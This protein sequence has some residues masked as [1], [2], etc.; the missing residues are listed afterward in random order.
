M[1]YLLI[2]FGASFVKTMVYDTSLGEYPI[3]RELQSVPSPFKNKDTIDRGS[4]VSFLE[5]IVSKIS[6]IDG[7]VICTILGGGWIDDVYHSWKSTDT[8]PKK[9]CLISGLFTNEKTYHIHT[10]HGGDVDALIP[11][12]KISDIV[13]YGSLGDT[14]CVIES[15]DLNNDEVAINIGT[16]S[17]V[18]SRE[19][20]EFKVVSFLPAGRAFLCFDK[21][22]QQLGCDFFSELNKITTKQVCSSTLNVDLNVFPQSKNFIN[23]GYINNIMEEDFTVTN[24]LGSI[25][26]CFV[27]QY[28]PHLEPLS[29][30]TIR[31]VG[32]IPLKLPILNDLFKHYYPNFT[33]VTTKSPISNTHIGMIRLIKKHL[34]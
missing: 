5:N 22:F 32:G 3:F 20:Q 21:F 1:R 14:K 13:V 30:K 12:G 16:G 6:D 7:I 11:L 34:L 29:K 8:C 10:H 31:L 4:L 15:L 27:L 26:R 28:K 19:N 18:I 24:L 2:D 25:L 9:H 23:G 33:I 17:Q